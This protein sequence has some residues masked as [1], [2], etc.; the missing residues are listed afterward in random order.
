LNEPL[1][2]YKMKVLVIGATGQFAGLVVPELKK[3]GITVYALVQDVDKGLRALQRGADYVI[4]GDL[5]NAKSLKDAVAG[6]DGVFHI[7]PAFALHEANLGISMVNA[8][9]EAR[10]KKFVFSSVY[11]PSLSMIN[12]AAKRPVEEALYESG[13]EFS[14]F[15]P[16]MY[17]QML[18]STWKSAKDSGQI[19]GAYSIH[20]KM[21]YV[22]YRDVAE[23]VAL[24]MAT[25]RLS[26]GTFELSSMGMFNRIDMAKLMSEA[27]GYKVEANEMA[28]DEWAKK[29][30]MPES[31][32]KEGLL[33]MNKHY[34]LYGFP[35]GNDLV[36]KTILGKNPHTVQGFIDEI[37]QTI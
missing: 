15:Q 13:M 7:N 29:V 4:T 1:N 11:H 24:A 16:A 5:N 18:N 12:H 2:F 21:C 30:N 20:S 23:A 25:N 32:M 36:L 10:V 26:Y 8:A 6:M 9:K 31:P 17:M 14:I 3:K 37:S 22:D 34:D 35:G 27:L 19:T 28:P 33:K